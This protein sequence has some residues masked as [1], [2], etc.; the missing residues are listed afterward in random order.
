[1][2]SS[3]GSVSLERSQLESYKV[4]FLL[5]NVSTEVIIAWAR[6]SATMCKEQITFVAQRMHTPT[7]VYTQLCNP[8]SELP[9]HGP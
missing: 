5:H 1:M 4:T 9:M 7:L 3:E 2:K 6:A 8:P